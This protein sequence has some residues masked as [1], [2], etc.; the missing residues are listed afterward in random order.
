[1]RG[2]SR[3]WGGG[4]GLANQICYPVTELIVT[5]RGKA[6]LFSAKGLTDQEPSLTPVTILGK[7]WG[8]QAIPQKESIV[9]FLGPHLR[10]VDC[11]RQHHEPGPSLFRSLQA[12]CV[13][14]QPPLQCGRQRLLC[15]NLP[16]SPHVC[17]NLPEAGR[18]V[19][20]LYF[21]LAPQCRN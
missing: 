12:T 3:T 4:E 7:V 10:T 1:M 21:H 11:G 2:S 16:P 15:P 14:Y 17:P 18:V 9:P 6:A 13:Q 19:C 20:R 8:F 5:R